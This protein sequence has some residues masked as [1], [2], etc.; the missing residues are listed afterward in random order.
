MTTAPI[1]LNDAGLAPIRH[2]LGEIRRCLS[3]TARDWLPPPATS[4]SSPTLG[5]PECRPRQRWQTD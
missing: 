1:D 2:D 4:P 3:E 5:T